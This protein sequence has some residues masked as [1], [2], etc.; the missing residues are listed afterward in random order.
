MNVALSMYSPF[1]AS[2]VMDYISNKSDYEVSYGYILFGLTI[3]SSFFRFM[4]ESQMNYKFG[5]IGLNMT[6]SITMLIYNK[7]LKYPSSSEKLFSESDIINYSQVDAER[8]TYMGFQLA[9]VI[10]CPLEIVIGIILMYKFVGVSFLSGIGAMVLSIALTFFVGKKS[11]VYNDEVLKVKDM[12]MKFTQELL[13]II[14]YVK[15]N[16]I[17]KFFYN[18]VDVARM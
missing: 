5:Q 14:R 3:I 16:T 1:L 11:I 9:A 15:I 13:D 6:N 4:S 7:A 10:L 8:M 12:R 2:Q 18:K 17:E